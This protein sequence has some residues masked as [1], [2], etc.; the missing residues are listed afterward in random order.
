[1]PGPGRSA[2]VDLQAQLAV[3]LPASSC[4]VGERGLLGALSR[5]FHPGVSFNDAEEVLSEPGW[6]SKQRR[7][8]RRKRRLLLDL[9]LVLFRKLLDS[10][11]Q[12]EP[13]HAR[14][15]T[16]AS[17]QSAQMSTS[18]GRAIKISS[19]RSSKPSTSPKMAV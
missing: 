9:S 2:G 17:G 12:S 13:A 14:R 19:G 15:K 4:E 10:V 5:S 3:R 18:A 6:P 7:A 8:A 16:F 1:M 11:W